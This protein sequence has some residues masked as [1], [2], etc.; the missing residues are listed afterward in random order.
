MKELKL[1]K[2]FIANYFGTLSKESVKDSP[3]LISVFDFVDANKDG[4]INEMEIGHFLNTVFD[5]GADKNVNGELEEA[6]I[7][8]YIEENKDIFSKLNIKVEDIFKLFGMFI[9]DSA[10]SD[11]GDDNVTDK[12]IGVKSYSQVTFRRNRGVKKTNLRSSRFIRKDNK[13]NN[14][15]VVKDG[16]IG[17]TEQGLT[18]D[19]WLLS[20]VNALSYTEK[21]QQLIKEA[22]EYVDG[23]TIVHLKGV[24]DYFISDDLVAQTKLRP[25]NYS[26]G[27]DDMLILELAMEGVRDDIAKGKIKSEYLNDEVIATNRYQSSIRSGLGIELYYSLAGKKSC[28][29]SDYESMKK[30][31]SE[32]E[33]NENCD[34]ALSAATPSKDRN[35]KVKD[36]YGKTVRLHGRHSYAIKN[37]AE[38]VVTITDPWN[39]E[40]EIKLDIE[41]FLGAFEKIHSIDLSDN[42][43][44]INETLYENII[45]LDDGM[46]RHE[47]KDNTGEIQQVEIK[48]NKGLIIYKYNKINSPDADNTWEV[49]E[50]LADGSTRSTGIRYSNDEYFYDEDVYSMRKKFPV[51]KEG[52][53]VV[54][55][56]NGIVRRRFE[57]IG[58]N[59]TNYYYDSEG[60]ITSKEEYCD[61]NLIRY[62]YDTRGNIVNKFIHDSKN[63]ISRS[64]QYEYDEE[65][66]LIN[67]I[68]N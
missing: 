1:D 48:N 23:G 58:D 42:N 40:K 41:V 35:I 17:K 33:M 45:P 19:C 49:S 3:E 47:Y 65:G 30:I 53:S 50:V 18:G 10:Q 52:V 64:I 20:A 21:G 5:S 2:T 24:G 39:S 63:E 27:D 31:L 46:T 51:R 4:K 15:S 29:H 68:E 11:E 59:K 55:D 61:G 37:V 14:Q 12:Y 43:P 7:A 60:N 13:R 66:N 32:Y 25:D 9:T 54:R 56:Q 6:E 8:A 26:S 16:I 38:G 44:D 57:V 22:L 62:S 28:E 34:L 67:T 36:I